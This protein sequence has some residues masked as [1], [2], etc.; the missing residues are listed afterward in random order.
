MLVAL[1]V[2]SPEKGSGKTTL[3]VGLGRYLQDA[4]KKVGYL[5]PGGADGDAEFMKD[6]LSLKEAAEA[7][8]PA[9]SGIKSACDKV[10][11]GK[12]VVLVESDYE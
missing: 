11:Q 1:L 7:L 5:K 2:T 12:D 3:C 8:S 10:A 4:G 6:A 9:L